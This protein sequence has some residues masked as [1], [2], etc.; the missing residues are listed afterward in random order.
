MHEVHETHQL[1][2]LIAS[3][4]VLGAAPLLHR[5]RAWSRRTTTIVDATVAALTALL[6]GFEVLPECFEAIG[7][8]A[9]LAAGVGVMIPLL[10]ERRVRSV[11]HRAAPLLAAG[12]LALHAATDGLAI[13]SA[14]G[15]THGHSHGLE[16]AVIMH[17]LPLG[18]ALWW[19]LRPKGRALAIAAL[20]LVGLS[21]VLG[22]GVGAAALPALSHSGL[23]L[24]QAFASG[25]LLHVLLHRPMGRA[26]DRALPWGL[27][28]FFVAVA[29]HHVV[30]EGLGA[31]GVGMG[32]CS[33]AAV[34]VWRRSR[35]T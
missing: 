6:I 13:A 15:A 28:I 25:L 21:T 26:L 12:A 10:A 9:L 3:I 7:S 4:A 23:I 35:G 17:R 14:H 33:M 18:L 5:L 8:L 27:G 31:W 29:V 30:F 34:F 2:Y 19:L 1:G 24:F 16:W 11:A 32:L 20:V 22:F